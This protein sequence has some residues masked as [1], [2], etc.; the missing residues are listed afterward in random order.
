[1]FVK[2]VPFIL[3]GLHHSQMLL[4]SIVAADRDTN[5]YTKVLLKGQLKPPNCGLPLTCMKIFI[6]DNGIKSL[7]RSSDRFIPPDSAVAMVKSEGECRSLG[8]FNN[9][10][11]L[12]LHYLL[13]HES[14]ASEYYEHVVRKGDKAEVPGLLLHYSATNHG[15]LTMRDRSL[16]EL[17]NFDQQV[18]CILPHRTPVSSI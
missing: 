12:G 1:M 14:S 3:T 10:G 11:E 17:F 7:C 6:S 15:P 9:E 2:I 4:R 8:H 5:L 16:E 13:Y 18:L